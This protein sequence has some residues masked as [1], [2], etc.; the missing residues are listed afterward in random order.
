MAS[1]DVALTAATV[2]VAAGL[3]VLVAERWQARRAPHLA[4]WTLALALFTGAA[5]ALWWG[6][7]LGWTP[8]SFRTFYLLGAVLN[9]PVL[10]LGSLYLSFPPAGVHRIAVVTGGVLCFAAGIVVATPLTAPVP[11]AGLPEGA[12]VLDVGPR[13]AGALASSLAAVVIVVASAASIVRQRRQRP[14]RTRVLLSNGFVIAGTATLSSGGLFASGGEELRGFALS[15]LVGV[16]LLSGGFV[17]GSSRPAGVPT[18]AVSRRLDA[19]LG[20]EPA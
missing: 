12:D 15:L 19:W 2:A 16:S 20:P 7:A 1:A 11:A 18:D 3:T 8:T 13:V 6:A 14:R 4:A 9:V 17:L 5:V 10:A